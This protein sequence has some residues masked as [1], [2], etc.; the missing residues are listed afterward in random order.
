MWPEKPLTAAR[1]YI[2]D[3]LFR[4]PA[5]KDVAYKGLWGDLQLLDSS[6]MEEAMR[7]VY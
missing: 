5:F 7:Q 1:A 6:I 3:F 4:H 2:D